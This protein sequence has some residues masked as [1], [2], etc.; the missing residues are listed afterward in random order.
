MWSQAALGHLSMS[1]H[2][3]APSQPHL[4]VVWPHSGHGLRRRRRKRSM[5]PALCSALHNRMLE[6]VAG[7]WYSAVGR[8]IFLHL[9]GASGLAS[10]S[11]AAS[12]SVPSGSA[13]APRR[14][15]PTQNLRP[16]S[17]R[18]TAAMSAQRR[19]RP[20]SH[21]TAE[22]LEVK[23]EATTTC[24]MRARNSALTASG[25]TRSTMA[26]ETMMSHSPPGHLRA[27]A[28]L[29]EVA[30]SSQCLINC[31]QQSEQRK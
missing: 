24:L 12:S 27:R 22:E 7:P 4:L 25:A 18:T 31:S 2:F 11:W 9:A 3:S 28:V 29:V 23:K 14:R 5:P 20:H 26:G 17:Q 13:V 16:Q 15:H 19:P 1:R 10:C 8:V 6:H 21:C 30:S